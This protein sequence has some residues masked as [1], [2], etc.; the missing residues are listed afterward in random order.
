MYLGGKLNN[1]APNPAPSRTVGMDYPRW[2]NEELSISYG[3]H[4]TTVD[5]PYVLSVWLWVSY[6]WMVL[7]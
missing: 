7:P 1:P 6:A 5:V 2:G 4:L 3:N